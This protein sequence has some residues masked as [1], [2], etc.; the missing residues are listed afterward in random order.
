MSQHNKLV[1]TF[2]LGGFVSAFATRLTDP[3]VAVLAVFAPLSS[4]CMI[5]VFATSNSLLQASVPDA[6][7]GRVMGVHAFLM[8]G[9]T[10]IGSAWAGVVAS[11]TSTASAMALGAGLAAASALLAV[12]LAPSLRRAKQTLV[13]YLPPPQ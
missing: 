12:C 2:A 5:C 3:L 10:P 13:E 11:R 7:R 1:L 8:M 4:F 6:L 9:L